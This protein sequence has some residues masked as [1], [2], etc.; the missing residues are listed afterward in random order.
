MDWFAL[1][2]C[3]GRKKN[4]ISNEWMIQLYF[5]SLRSESEVQWMDDPIIFCEFTKWKWSPKSS[6]E[7]SIQ[8]HIIFYVE[9]N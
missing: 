5:V 2:I 3:F 1:I 4:K 8:S 6:R 7:R 9:N